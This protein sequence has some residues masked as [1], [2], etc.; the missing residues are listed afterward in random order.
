MPQPEGQPSERTYRYSAR[1]RWTYRA[2]ALAGGLMAAGAIALQ[3]APGVD[4]VERGQLLIFAAVFAGVAVHAAAAVR[5]MR[6]VVRLGKA[7]LAGGTGELVPWSDVVRVEIQPFRQRMNVFDVRG[8]R[9]LSLRPELE[10]F[11]AVQS[12]IVEH[13]QPRGCPPP[14]RIPLLSP[15]AGAPIAI[16]SALLA[17]WIGPRRG[18]LPPAVFGGVSLLL[19]A[20]YLARRRWIDVLPDRVVL[21]QGW[22]SFTVPYRE[23]SAVHVQAQPRQG[24]GALHYVVLERT[25]ADAIPIAGFRHGYHDAFRSIEPAWRAAAHS[26]AARG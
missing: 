7:G 13:M 5:S 23:I 22:R 18:L 1:S 14:C 24:G 19:A 6:G 26:G 10:A 8:R 21:R 25:G 3:F 15:F 11:A 4:A 2:A 12:Y 9:L 20:L 16:F 17:V